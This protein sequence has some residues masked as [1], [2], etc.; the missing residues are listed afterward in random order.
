MILIL[1]KAPLNRSLDQLYPEIDQS[2][3]RAIN[4]PG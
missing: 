2:R 1:K 3:D 4:E